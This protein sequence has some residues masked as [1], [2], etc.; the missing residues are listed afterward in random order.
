MAQRRLSDDLSAPVEAIV[1]TFSARVEE[2]R[3]PGNYFVLFCSDGPDLE[4]GFGHSRLPGSAPQTDTVFRIASCTKSFTAA[5]LL[6]LRD[7]G[8]LDL[9]SPITAFVP[10]FLATEP[11][12]DPVTPTVRMLMSMSGGL[13][14][15]DPWGDRQ[16]SMTRE[17]LTAQLQAGIPF[18]SIPGTAFEYSNLGYAL[19]GQVIE[20]ITG[21]PYIDVVTEELLVPLGLTSTGY[22]AGDVSGAVLARGYRKRGDE[23]IELPYSEP[24]VFSPMGGLFSSPRDLTRWA[25]WLASALDPE[26]AQPGPLSA[27][28]RRE[29]QQI[30][31]SI[32]AD[33]AARFDSPREHGYGF[34]LF[35]DKDP[36]W[37][38]TVSHSGGYPGFST[39]MRWNAQ[40]GIGI[41]GFE[42]A[43][44]AG[45]KVPVTE[46]LDLAVRHLGRR[47]P[48]P[49]PWPQTLALKEEAESLVLDW[50]QG[51]A[52]R[53]FAE[54]VALDIPY[55]ERIGAIAAAIAE[56]G[57]LRPTRSQ[58]APEVQG[59]SPAHLV[60]YLPGSR[61][62]LRCEIRLAPTTPARIQTFIVTAD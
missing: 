15:D 25:S 30:Q 39:H 58:R 50:D 48:D 24:G 62:R 10:A 8:L 37:G 43:T 59:D 3:T 34:G 6:I 16:E 45:V 55:R 14:T 61:G 17:E 60:W 20:A 28:S 52:D 56:V 32:A 31:R 7:R 21:R 11:P 22:R 49:A 54:N 41:V 47:A 29:M 35:V 40:A 42:N 26:L 9:D 53:I 57:G 13:P 4:A 44:Y 19:L 1:T 27:A 18:V 33:P 2:G 38:T 46:A 5:T 23:W 36:V 51:T 12:S